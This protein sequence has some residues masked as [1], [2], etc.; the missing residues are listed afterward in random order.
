MAKNGKCKDPNAC[1][2]C[3]HC[4]R[5][6][7]I[8]IQELIQEEG[9]KESLAAEALVRKLDGVMGTQDDRM[10]EMM[11]CFAGMILPGVQNQSKAN[12]L[13]GK[14]TRRL[15]GRMCN[16]DV[17]T[18]NQAAMVFDTEFPKILMEMFNDKSFEK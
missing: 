7:G 9:E 13:A 6:A 5:V 11:A 3:F 1:S 16:K 10:L 2:D 4:L 17:L 12:K 18:T 14:A 15:V 8:R